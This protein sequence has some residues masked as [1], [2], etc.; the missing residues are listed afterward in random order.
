MTD[1]LCFQAQ[2]DAFLKLKGATFYYIAMFDE[3]NPNLSPI[4]LT[5]M[6]NP[7]A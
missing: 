3:V 7:N 1:R 2:T 5:L 6:P 4:T